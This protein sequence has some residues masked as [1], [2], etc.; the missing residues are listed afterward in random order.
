MGDIWWQTAWEILRPV[1]NL[2]PDKKPMNRLL[3]II[4]LAQ[5]LTG[6][7]QEELLIFPGDFDQALDPA[8]KVDKDI[9]LITI[10]REKGAGAM[11]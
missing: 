1:E 5:R 10:S 7:G 4:I 3:I 11:V 2:N 8:Q 9:F 6:F